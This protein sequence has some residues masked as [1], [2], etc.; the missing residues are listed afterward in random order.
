MFSNPQNDK[1]EGLTD[2]FEKQMLL[3]RRRRILLGGA[4]AAPVIMTLSNSA[5]AANCGAGNVASPSAAVSGNLSRPS[6]QTSTGLSPGYWKNHS[7]WPGGFKRGDES[8]SPSPTLF[9]AYFPTNYPAAWTAS[10]STRPTF[11]DVI[12]PN[13]YSAP[14]PCRNGTNVDFARACVASLLNAANGAYTDTSSG[15][16]WLTA[17]TIQDMW[18]KA[19]GSGTWTVPG[20]TTQWTASQC[21]AYL[22]RVWDAANGCIP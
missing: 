4:G 10:T 19:G 9:K 13:T 14:N 1:D 15:G 5:L 6:T 18:A 2:A 11:L 16:Q 8:G 21:T 12:S 7:P 3:R 22:V 17:A 20:T